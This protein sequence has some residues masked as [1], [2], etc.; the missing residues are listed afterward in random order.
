LSEDDR[1]LGDGPRFYGRRRGHR[2]RPGRR[3]LIESFLPRFRIELPAAGMALDVAALFPE[4]R[5]EVW[6]EVGFG[7]GEHLAAQAATNPAVGIIGCEPFVNGVAALLDRIRD[8]GLDNVR[9]FDDDA[10]LLIPSL[11]EA[12]VGRLFLLFLDPWPKKR[13]HRRRFV[14]GPV[15][16]HLARVLKD[17]AEVRFASDHGGYV[18]WTLAR[19]TDHPQFQWTARRPGDWRRRPDDAAESRYERKARAAGR[20]PAYLSFRRRERA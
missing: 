14:D 16:D 18:A 15:L 12:S 9:V 7:A 2:L 17:G 5:R 10:R 6:L 13:H 8:Q 19:F 1:A 3:S 20:L 11:P 4:P